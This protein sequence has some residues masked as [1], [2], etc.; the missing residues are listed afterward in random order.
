MHWANI[1]KVMLQV[2]VFLGP[3]GIEHRLFLP[4]PLSQNVSFP[5]TLDSYS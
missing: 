2:T 4:A 1:S 5:R 3:T